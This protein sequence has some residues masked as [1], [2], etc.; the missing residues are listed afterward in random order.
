MAQVI[1][2]MIDLTKILESRIIKALELTRDEIFE[3]VSRKVF[4]YYE[5]P[6]FNSPDEREPD[7]YSRTYKLMESLTGSNV[8]KHDDTY[9]FTVGWDDDYLTFKYSGGF[10]PRNS[11]GRYNGITGLQVL[12]SFNSG[13]HG[14]TVDGSHNYWDEAIN[15][16]GGKNGIKNKFKSNLKK[17]GVPIK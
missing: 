8:I 14:Y 3:V 5:E 12:Q 16:L 9:E 11:N 4:D 6:V 7:Y 13:T 2:S 1:K 15:E 17:C 10:V